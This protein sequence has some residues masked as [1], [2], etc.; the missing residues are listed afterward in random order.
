[1]LYELD[2][3]PDI[4]GEIKTVTVDTSLSLHFFKKMQDEN[5]LSKNFVGNL[6]LTETDPSKASHDDLFNAP[7]IAYRNANPNGMGKEEFESRLPFD[8]DV[9]SVIYTDIIRGERK[10]DGTMASS[11]RR[12]TQRKK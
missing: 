3:K 10:K 8:I 5:L 7:Y 6:A 12:V 4:D 9:C 1:M 2:L 11:F